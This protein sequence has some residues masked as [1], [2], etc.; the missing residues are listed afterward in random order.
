MKFIT[1]IE[2]NPHGTHIAL[3]SLSM[4]KVIMLKGRFEGGNNN[5]QRINHAK[6][7]TSI[8]S[9]PQNKEL[10][11]LTFFLDLHHV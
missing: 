1:K 8:A 9:V 3:T 6:S 4:C 5:Q 10:E 11:L 7:K 2:N